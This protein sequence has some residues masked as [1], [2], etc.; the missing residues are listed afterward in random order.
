MPLSLLETLAPLL[1]RRDTY[2]FLAIAVLA[3][4][5][6]QA[7]A[8]VKADAALL[9]ERPKV[10]DKIEFKSDIDRKEGPVKIVRV[11]APAPPAAAGA[12]PSA[13]AAPVLLSETIERGPVETIAVKERAEE[14]T[15][16]PACPAPA[17]A[18]DHWRSMGVMADPLSEHKLVGL[19]GGVTLKKRLDLLLG[20]R[21]EPRTEGSFQVGVRF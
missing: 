16:T 21:L 20:L 4:L 14:K 15:V 7:R 11:Y 12:C 10:E 5:L 13:P 9:A 6:R 19:Y 2:Y 17:E 18:D 1:K 3:F 8:T